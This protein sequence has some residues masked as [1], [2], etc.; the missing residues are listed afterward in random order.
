MEYKLS[1]QWDKND[2]FIEIKHLLIII[3]NFNEL[4]IPTQKSECT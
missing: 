1:E 2:R 4:G 3:L